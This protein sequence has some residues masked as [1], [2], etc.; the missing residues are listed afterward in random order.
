MVNTT[1]LGMV[2][3]PPLV[4]PE[5]VFAALSPE[6]LVCDI[7]YAPARDAAIAWRARQRA[8]RR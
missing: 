4:L 3:K 2:G 6:A 7:V 1:S 5:A 8:Y